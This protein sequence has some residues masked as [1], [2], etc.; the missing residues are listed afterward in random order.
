MFVSVKQDNSRELTDEL[1]RVKK[2]LLTKKNKKKALKKSYDNLDEKY[3]ALQAQAD[4]NEKLKK[5]VERLEKLMGE[6][7][8]S[9]LV[10]VTTTAG[11]A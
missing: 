10:E 7:S 1:E 5:E 11:R 6:V 4:E 2:Q 8:I 9:H 3:K